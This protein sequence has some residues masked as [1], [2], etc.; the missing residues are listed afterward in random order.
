MIW[1]ENPLFLETS[2]LTQNLLWESVE[3]SI[4]EWYSIDFFCFGS[5]MMQDVNMEKL[6]IA[7]KEEH[8]KGNVVIQPLI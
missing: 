7:S 6:K 8:D 3:T 2:I 5:L 4:V 1:G